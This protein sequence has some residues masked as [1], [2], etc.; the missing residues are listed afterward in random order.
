MRENSRGKRQSQA[1]ESH[2]EN[3]ADRQENN[4]RVSVRVVLDQRFEVNIKVRKNPHQ[5]SQICWEVDLDLP[6]CEL[7]EDIAPAAVSKKNQ[8][9]PRSVSASQWQPHVWLGILMVSVGTLV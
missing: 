4:Q 8:N 1:I 3:R 2:D 6:A 5:K 9:L 7:G